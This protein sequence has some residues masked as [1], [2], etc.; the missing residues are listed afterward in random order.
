[1]RLSGPLH[2]SAGSS[3]TLR[4][5]IGTDGAR[6]KCQ[7][8]DDDGKPMKA[9]IVL[10]ADAPDSEPQLHWNV[11]APGKYKVMAVNRD[12][13]LPE[14]LEKLRAALGNAESIELAPKAK[15]E[16]SLKALSID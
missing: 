6:L 7:A 15:V 13:T 12:V 9:A 3:A 2:L 8:T 4:V 11:L 16:L 10:V 14:D 1:M 5:L